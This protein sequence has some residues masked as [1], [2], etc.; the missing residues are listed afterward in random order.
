MRLSERYRLQ[1]STAFCVAALLL[2]FSVSACETPAQ[3]A[4]NAQLRRPAAEEMNRICALHGDERAE[5]LKKLK[6]QTGLELYC[7]DE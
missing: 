6:E 7:S 1:A 4:R 3:E 2:V 5:Q